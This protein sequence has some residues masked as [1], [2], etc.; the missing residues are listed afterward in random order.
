MFLMKKRKSKMDCSECREMIDDYLEGK[1][2]KADEASF[3]VHLHTCPEC[4][5]LVR[6][7]ELADKIITAEKESIPDFYLTEKIMSGIRSFETEPDPLLVR[8]LK[9]ALLTISVA[10]AIGAG[11]LIGN[12]SRA[13]ADTMVPV[14]LALMNDAELESVNILAA[15]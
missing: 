5:E 1:F 15:E 12:I 4:R 10:A 14:E 9:P 2:G 7:Q 11:I 3:E 8:I 6:M 13:A